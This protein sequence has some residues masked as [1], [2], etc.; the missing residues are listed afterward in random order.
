MGSYQDLCV[1]VV[2]DDW[3]TG[4]IP[5]GIG[6]P[7][8]CTASTINFIVG[9][10]LPTDYHR[11]LVGNIGY[12]IKSTIVVSDPTFA[13]DVALAATTAPDCQRSLNGFKIAL[14]WTQTLK[15][16][17]SKCRDLAFRVF[18]ADEKV[19]Y[20]KFQRTTY[21]SFDPLLKIGDEPIKFIGHDEIPLFKYLGRKFQVD[22]KLNFILSEI[23]G[24]LRIGCS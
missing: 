21:S 9:F 10:Q 7:Q 8:G 11:Y 24:K 23:T 22:L 15:P 4:L 1:R 17:A 12:R 2:S 18:M 13:D 6:V 19:V 16:K 5:I 14:D 3:I 20:T